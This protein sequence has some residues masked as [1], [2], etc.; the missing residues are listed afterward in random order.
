MG[1]GAHMTSEMG[2][3]KCEAKGNFVER[4]SLRLDGNIMMDS[5]GMGWDDVDWID[6][7]VAKMT[8]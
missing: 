6:L 5:T 7:R 1:Q 3:C 2:E 4:Y 8:L